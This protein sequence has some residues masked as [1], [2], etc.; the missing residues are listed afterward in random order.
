MGV[1][2]GIDLGTTNSCVAIVQ[3]DQAR[4]VESVYGDRIHPSIICFHPSGDVLAGPRAKERLAIDPENTIYSFKRLLGQDIKEPAIQKLMSHLP[5]N[6]I[7]RNGIPVLQTRHKEATLPEVSALMLKYLREMCEETFGVKIDEA[8]ITV[9]ANFTDVQRASTKIAGRIAGF[10]VLRILN[11]PTAAALAYGFGGDREERIAVYDFGGGTFD[12]TI[13]E[14]LDDIFEV[15]STAGDNFLGGDDFDNKIVFEML[16]QF[17]KKHGFSIEDNPVAMQRV[18]S[19][20]ERAKCQL[21]SIKE[22]NATLRELVTDKRGRKIDF[23]FTLTRERFEALANALVERT[24]ATC[25]EALE[26]AKL[27]PE[28]LD[29][30][31]LVGGSTRI[32]LVRR[33]VEEFFNR[34]PRTQINPDEVVAIGA[35]I[36]AFSLTQEA[37]DPSIKARKR[38]NVKVD[39]F[40]SRPA[41]PAQ[42][43]RAGAAS[44]PFATNKSPLSDMGNPFVAGATPVSSKP[45]KTIGKIELE[46]KRTMDGL[47]EPSPASVGANSPASALKSGGAS[48]MS[49]KSA[50]RVENVDLPGLPDKQWDSRKKGAS[51]PPQRDD[52]D[53]DLWGGVSGQARSSMAD[54]PDLPVPLGRPSRISGGNIAPL[55]SEVDLPI[56]VGPPEGGVDYPIPVDSSEKGLDL[57]ARRETVDLPTRK[58]VTDLPATRGT[59]DLPA[60]KEVTDLPDIRGKVDLPTTPGKTDLPTT[61]GKTDLPAYRDEDLSIPLGPPNDIGMDDDIDVD[62]PLAPPI[63]EAA[64]IPKRHDNTS[65][66]ASGRRRSTDNSSSATDGAEVLNDADIEELK[67]E[68]LRASRP[69]FATPRMASFQPAPHRAP[70]QMVAEETRPV[71]L[72]PVDAGAGASEHVFA[73]GS[74]PPEFEPEIEDDFSAQK[75]PSYHPYHPLDE[76][77]GDDGREVQ[78]ETHDAFV[79]PVRNATPAVLLDVSPRG[80]GIATA[81]GYCDIIIERN[82]AIPI[83]QSRHF[84]TS[85]DNQT[86]V[87]IDVYQGESRRTE[88]NTQL[89]RIEMR[90]LR[91]AARGEISIMITF[92][93][94]TDGI[95]NV[96]ALNEET[97]ESQSTQIKLTGGLADDQVQALVEKYSGNA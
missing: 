32:P 16:T 53:L 56:P 10:N 25:E 77:V 63:I 55:A 90:G 1:A 27:K 66:F 9:P 97:K 48:E 75:R 68:E 61:A 64:G 22:V 95:L 69:L 45:P 49:A 50:G 31:V 38:A 18:R 59:I 82:A 80:L 62:V 8:I 24:L 93:V 4:I 6:V 13:I 86:E 5:Y 35:A 40:A 65:S 26:L 41:P 14:L 44:D 2:V 33:Q 92:E 34:K 70:R 60:R 85:R 87:Y 42:S 29:N 15:L 74:I 7:E 84:S 79:V 11:E 17:K 73:R 76:V 67:T 91:P 43:K 30:V 83:E 46:H 72:P 81:G 96:R 54:D 19:V 37:L 51:H 20:A 57:P 47:M 58:E 94:D 23:S 39:P 3:G 21:S 52:S 28:D 36:N 78:P 71:A 88:E 89:G 12:I